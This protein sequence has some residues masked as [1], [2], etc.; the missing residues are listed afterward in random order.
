MWEHYIGISLW[1]N[2]MNVVCDNELINTFFQF[3]TYMLAPYNLFNKAESDTV[4]LRTQM[5]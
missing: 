1:K 5:Q 2:M 4:I 3:Y